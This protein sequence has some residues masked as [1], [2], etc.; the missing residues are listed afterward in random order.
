MVV[1]GP[2]LVPVRVFRA[3]V[4]S[5]TS[6]KPRQLVAEDM[7]VATEPPFATT[8]FSSPFSTTACTSRTLSGAHPEKTKETSCVSSSSR[9]SSDH[10]PNPLRT[11]FHSVAVEPA[12]PAMGL[13]NPRCASREINKPIFSSRARSRRRTVSRGTSPRAMSSSK[14]SCIAPGSE[15]MRRDCSISSVFRKRS[16]RVNLIRHGLLLVLDTLLFAL[17]TTGSAVEKRPD[18][19]EVDIADGWV[20]FVSAVEL[21]FA[22]G[23]T[24]ATSTGLSAGLLLALR[25]RSRAQDRCIDFRLIVRDAKHLIQIRGKRPFAQ[26]T[27]FLKDQVGN[28]GPP[29]HPNDG[30]VK[31]APALT[32][33]HSN[34]LCTELAR[35]FTASRIF[36]VKRTTAVQKVI[37][38]YKAR[39]KYRKGQV[40]V[41][42]K[43][44]YKV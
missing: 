11:P 19:G 23:C 31:I 14:L 36:N 26:Y 15:P 16:D 10:S 13:R 35:T 7:A 4:A 44:K 28:Q 27:V 3:A 24:A 30:E 5:A 6:S 25:C 1:L 32:S 37:L 42:I 33:H 17:Q 38:C 2:S 9:T 41:G 40:N 8:W 43:T 29:R 12:E 20:E 34:L 39:W 22:P 18:S 21:N